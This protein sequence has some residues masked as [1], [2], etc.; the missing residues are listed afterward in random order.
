ME[1]ARQ[2]FATATRGTTSPQVLYLSFEFY[3]RA[4]PLSSA[5]E[6]LQQWLAVTGQN[7][8]TKETA[9]A[10]SNLAIIYQTR[11]DLDAAEEM[12]RKALAI[13]KQ[14]KRLEQTSYHYSNLGLIYQTRGDLDRAEE[15]HRKALAVEERC[16]RSEAMSDQF[17]HLALIQQARGD[18][19]RA[20][21]MHKK[22]L[23]LYAPVDF[24]SRQLGI[25]TLPVVVH[26]VYHTPAQNISDAQVASQIAVLNKD[27]RAGNDDISQVPYAFRRAI[28][29][30]RIEF[31]LA[32][33][34]PQG[35]PTNGITRTH[36]QRSSFEGDRVKRGASGGIDPWDTE[37]YLNIWVCSLQ[38]GLVGFAQFPGGRKDTDGVVINT[39][40]FGTVG[41]ATAP[42]NKGR[43]TT[44]TIGHYLD[45]RHPWG[46]EASAADLPPHSQPNFG[47]P[48][49]PHISANNGPHGDMFVNFMDY[50]D[51]DAMHMF[52][53]GQ[54]LRMHATLQGPRENLAV[55]QS[56]KAGA[57]RARRHRSAAQ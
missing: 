16:K 52:T 24:A 35:Q 36:T 26:V 54:V 51:D 42:F 57:S 22:A 2:L 6:I 56:K 33:K 9:T 55:P 47:S 8:Q 7:A 53:K 29:D 44:H 21:E 50:V 28:G 20:E 34:D 4:G 17:T 45:L 3:W 49:F 48:S 12:H 15:M 27:Y 43:T 39:T 13:D 19:T 5:E 18:F 38:G 11:G 40:A 25:V 37:R 10:L 32:T 1:E 46:G 14:L 41:S 31:R 30:A 23:S